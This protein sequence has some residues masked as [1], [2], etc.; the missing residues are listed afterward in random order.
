M[1]LTWDDLLEK[2]YMG[3]KVDMEC[4]LAEKAIP[5]SVYETYCSFANSK[6]GDIVLGVE[7]DKSKSDPKERFILRG[8]PDPEKLREDFWNTIN[9]QKVNANILVDDD[10]YTVD[11]G[12]LAL[13]VIHVPRADYTMRPVYKGENPF[14][15]TYKRNHEGD[16]HAKEYEVRAMI[17]DQSSEG[18][19]STILEGFTMNDIDVDSLRRYR[20][21]FNTSH[22]DH[23]WRE[24]PDQEFLEMLGG[25]RRD[26]RDKLE[27]L[28]VAGLMMFGT[29]LAIRDEFDNIFMDYRDETGAN[30]T[31]RWTDRVTYDGTWENN[32]F[33]FFMKVAP[34]LTE[35]LKRPFV[36]EN[37]QRIDDTPV[38]EAIREA[39]VN[40]IIHSD[41]RM[42]S[43]V[44]KIIK[45][46]NGFT[47]TNPGS[48]K[49]PKEQIYSGGNSKARNPHM[50]T[51][52]RMIGF[53]DNAGSGF[54]KILNVWADNG[55]QRPELDE[56]IVMNQVTLT[57]L[58]SATQSEEKLDESKDSSAE[59]AEKSAES[60]EK[61]AES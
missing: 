30:A 23:V 7:E 25:Y 33:N 15:G 19:D 43:G 13:L 41:Y 4:K 42:D 36:L 9:S 56:D 57:L 31:Q 17:R 51:M 44:L 2:I 10:V 55:W 18:N 1:M 35:N 26:R 61:S 34:K 16:Y 46:A 48:L 24:L 22:P 53:G 60:A 52:L 38:H 49:L 32:L 12:D 54:P 27:G 28:T 47:F 39:F 50:Q 3:E 5:Q 45:T 59:S 37:M 20:V 14:K 21:M 29:G 40:L 6:G 11:N 58:L 8:V